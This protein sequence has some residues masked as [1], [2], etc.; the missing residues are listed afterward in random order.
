MSVPRD[1]FS[2]GLSMGIH[3]YMFKNAV[4]GYIH[5][6]SSFLE[7]GSLVLSF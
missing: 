4:Y 6:L 5:V 7:R 3:I 1:L 2:P